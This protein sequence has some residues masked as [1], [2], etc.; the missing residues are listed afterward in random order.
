[1]GNL[2]YGSD[3]RQRLDVYRPRHLVATAPVIVFLYGGRWQHGSRNEYRLLGDAITRRGLV[4]VIPDYRLYPEVR[5]PAWVEDAAR[6]VGWV[7]DSIAQ[8]GGDPG[9]IVVVGHSAGAHTAALLALDPQYLREAGMPDG[10]VQGFVSMAGP[11]ATVWTDPDVQAL[12]GPREDWAATYPMELVD[13]TEPPLL[14]L[15]GARDETVAPASAVRLADRVRE[16]GGCAR[17][18]LYQGLGHIGIVVAPAL[19]RFNVAPVLEDVLRFVRHP[20]AYA[21]GALR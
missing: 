13:G 6:A 1:M 20:S 21:C 9:R 14:L 17:A 18:I 12:M 4:A 5:F 19:D 15:Q 7:R 3:A 8:Y 16:R 10:S 2:P 11:V